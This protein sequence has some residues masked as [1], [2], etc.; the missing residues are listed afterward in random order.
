MKII[1]ELL[2]DLKPSPPPPPPQN[3]N[4]HTPLSMISGSTA[5]ITLSPSSI[6]GGGC[7][8][9]FNPHWVCLTN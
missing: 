4:T 5:K 7:S 9:W 1:E 2:A 3:K 8:C 6:M